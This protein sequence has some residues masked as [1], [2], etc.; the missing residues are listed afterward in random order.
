M[1]QPRA[2]PG[3]PP[4]ICHEPEEEWWVVKG[5][6]EGGS[7]QKHYHTNTPFSAGQSERGA[8]IGPHEL[9]GIRGG[10]GRSCS[11]LGFYSLRANSPAF[12]LPFFF[13]P[14]RNIFTV[15]IM[16][17]EEVVIQKPTERAQCAGK[18]LEEVLVSAKDND[19]LTVGVYECAK[20]MNL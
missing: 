7:T 19:S 14:L 16:T 20:V 17:F 15:S 12:F 18:A 9:Q 1:D 6:E 3:D 2:W 8:F 13:F 5:G 10:D 4:S 11:T